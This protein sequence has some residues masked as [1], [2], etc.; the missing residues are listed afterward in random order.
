MACSCSLRSGRGRPP[1]VGALFLSSSFLVTVEEGT[2]LKNSLTRLQN[3][4]PLWFYMWSSINDYRDP[5]KHTTAKSLFQISIKEMHRYA[6]LW[7]LIIALWTPHNH[8]S[9]IPMV[10][11]DGLWTICVTNAFTFVKLTSK[12]HFLASGMMTL[13][14]LQRFDWN[15]FIFF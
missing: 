8:R 10:F 5:D 6:C 7:T 1:P 3:Y 12:C 14:L 4:L 15:N 2:D 11:H 13:L 9:F